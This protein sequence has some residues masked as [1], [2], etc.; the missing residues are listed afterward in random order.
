MG[1]PLPV[2]LLFWVA[3]VSYF[4]YS[5][6]LAG[7][8]TYDAVHFNGGFASYVH[9]TTQVRH[10]SSELINR[11]RAVFA[12]VQE[13]ICNNTFGFV[14]VPLGTQFEKPS[15]FSSGSFEMGM[16]CFAVTVSSLIQAIPHG[17]KLWFLLKKI[18]EGVVLVLFH[19]LY[20][21]S[22]LF[23]FSAT[24]PLELEL[25]LPCITSTASS[26]TIIFKITMSLK[27]L[28]E[29]FR[30]G[31][32][33]LLIS[34]CLLPMALCCPGENNPAFGPI[35][36]VIIMNALVAPLFLKHKIDKLTPLSLVMDPVVAVIMIVLLRLVVIV[37]V[38]YIRSIRSNRVSG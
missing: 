16:L 32:V 37:A 15:S 17:V 6:Y 23:S 38:S 26:F 4:I 27:T 19:V 21:V 20:L 30:V 33:M 34:V 5:L 1:L 11:D 28:L 22:V 35:G 10:V 29:F 8:E 36:L 25:D 3:E 9:P 12:N 14:T 13:H 24:L 2:E 18:K 31:S 7:K